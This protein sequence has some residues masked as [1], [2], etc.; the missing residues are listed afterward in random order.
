MAHVLGNSQRL[1]DLDLYNG[2]WKRFEKTVSTH[3]ELGEDM[4]TT[5]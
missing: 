2:G 4:T 3:Y 5:R 1:G